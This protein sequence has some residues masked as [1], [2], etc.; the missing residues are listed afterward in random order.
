MPPV[1]P[2]KTTTSPFKN[3]P[4]ALDLRTTSLLTISRLAP[5]MSWEEMAKGDGWI[6]QP[7]CMPEKANLTWIAYRLG[8]IMSLR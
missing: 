8:L 5:K 3:L 6:G 1:P 7:T 4:W 2:T